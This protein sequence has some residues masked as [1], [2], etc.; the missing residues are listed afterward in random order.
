MKKIIVLAVSL[1]LTFG[2]A[3]CG[4]SE[5]SEPTPE[6]FTEEAF[7]EEIQENIEVLNSCKIE[8][9][10]VE[11]DYDTR[12]LALFESEE[13]AYS[14]DRIPAKIVEMPEQLSYDEMQTEWPGYVADPALVEYMKVINFSSISEVEEYI[15]QYVDSYVLDSVCNGDFDEMLHANLAEIDGSL[16]LMR[17]GR[18]YGSECYDE[19]S[20]VY[21]DEYDG[22]HYVQIDVLFFD[23]Y[24]HSQR[25]EFTESSDGWIITDIED[26]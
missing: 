10:C 4:S 11:A 14:E 7:M 16:Y 2:L 23:D 12:Y 26:N 3:G 6:P 20:A 25:V 21:L 5:P 15:S 1:V 13:E 18:G 17:G 9:F 22:K 24:D 19:D 8:E